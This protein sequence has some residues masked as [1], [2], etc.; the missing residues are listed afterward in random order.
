MQILGNACVDLLAA[1]RVV[2]QRCADTHGTG[3]CDDELDGIRR[4]GDAALTDDR[5]VVLA[6]H[7]IHLVY[8]QQ[9][10]RFD[11]RT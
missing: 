7:V 5:Y 10:D 11:C 3:T 6:G 2:E 1:H 4:R 9:R 8:F